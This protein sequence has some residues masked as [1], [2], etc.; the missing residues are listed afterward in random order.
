MKTLTVFIEKVKS[1]IVTLFDAD[2]L[3]QKQPSSFNGPP[4]AS[5]RS[6]LLR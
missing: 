5:Q 1:K 2:R 6:T 4:I 3:E